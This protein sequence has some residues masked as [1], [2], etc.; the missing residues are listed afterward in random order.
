[1]RKTFAP[2]ILLGAMFAQP[3]L[4]QTGAQ[5][6]PPQSLFSPVPVGQS[7]GLYDDQAAVQQRNVFVNMA[8]LGNNDASPFGPEDGVLFNLF[9]GEEFVGKFT[10]FTPIRN[11]GYIANFDLEGYEHGHA[12]FSVVD[13]AVVATIHADDMVYKVNYVGSGQATVSEIDHT[14]EPECGTHGHGLEIDAGEKGH[15]HGGNGNRFVDHEIDSMVVYTDNARVSNGGTN[16][17]NA[18]INLAVHETN[19]AY[20]RSDVSQRLMLVHTEE[21]NW[22]EDGDDFG[23]L[24][25]LAGKTDGVADNVHA[26]RD[27]YGADV[28]TLIYDTGS[29][30]GV[31][32]IMTTLSAA[33]ESSAFSVVADSCATGYYSFAHELGHNMGSAHDRANAGSAL[34]TYSF[35]WRTTDNAY[36]SVMAYSP[37]TRIPTFSNPVK[38][39]PNGLALGT[40]VDNNA[41]SLNYSATTVSAWRSSK[42]YGHRV[43]TLMASNNGQ[44][45][46][47]FNITP[48]TDIQVWAMK[49]NTSATGSET[50]NVWVYEGGYFGHENSSSG[51]ELWGSDV[52]TGTGTDLSTYIYPGTRQFDAD[53]TYGIYVEMA[54]Y[55]GAT[56]LRY[57]NGATQTWENNY[58]QI[59][60]GIGKGAGWGGAVYLD[61]QWNGAIYYD[62]AAGQ[63]QLDTT[64]ASNNGFAG[65][66]FDVDVENDIVINSFDVNIDASA[67]PGTA[68]VD[69]WMRTGSHVGHE[70]NVNSWTYVGTDLAEIAA[71]INTGTRIAV[72][73]IHLSAGQTYAFYIHLASYADGHILKYTNSTGTEYYENSDMR[74][75][76]GK[77]MTTNTFNQTGISNRTWNGRINYSG[78]HAGPHLWLADLAGGQTNHVRMA[79][80]TPGALQYASWSV[81]GG[82]PQNSAWG[83]VYLSNPYHTLPPVAADSNGNVTISTYSPPGASGLQVWVQSLD[84]GTLTL[85]NGANLLIQ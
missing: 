15:D 60:S 73:D 8:L 75:H 59:E 68:H 27:T 17:I 76:T 25:D 81:A 9:E 24:S 84:V 44:A 70:D 19:M 83:T 48:K 1:M 34:T 6:H 74:I 21:I 32:Y 45:G 82:G 72:G 66:M 31:A 49:I 18:L 5:S 7:V 11:N 10:G 2:L 85:T 3:L 33:F 46:N 43:E 40:S 78:D 26:L 42:N 65:N 30:C 23:Y 63:V 37:G 58:L 29:Y 38:D 39:A 55:T 67:A 4:A 35:G 50:Y 47:M 71:S 69:V 41:A 51:W 62:G 61:R 12:W 52:V 20:S 14:L 53:T 77:G 28:V 79:G 22:F 57:T 16:G 80:C 36:R 13:E 64:F 56:S 54:S